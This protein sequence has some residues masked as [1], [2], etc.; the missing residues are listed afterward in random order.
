MFVFLDL[1]WIILLRGSLRWLRFAQLVGLG[2]STA[3]LV[4]AYGGGSALAIEIVLG[5]SGAFA[6]MEPCLG[7][8]AGCL[9]FG[10][11]M[12]WGVIPEE[13]CR[14]CADFGG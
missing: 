2:F 4:L 1:I 9:V 12:R 13:T 11:L 14:W 6:L 7:F 3:A 10:H 8:C 5:V